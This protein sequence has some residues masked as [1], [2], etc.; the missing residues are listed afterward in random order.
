MVS[1][2]TKIRT[3]DETS[4][5][6]GNT[7]NPGEPSKQASIL[8]IITPV[9]DGTH[10]KEI[11][12]YWAS[13]VASIIKGY[14]NP[15]N[16]FKEKE[17]DERGVHNIFF[18][19]ALE[20]ELTKRFEQ[21]NRPVKS[22]DRIEIKIEDF[23]L[24]VKPDFT[25]TDSCIECKCPEKS[26]YEIPE[27]YM[28]QLECEYRATGKTTYL[29]AFQRPI[30]LLQYKPSDQRW[31]FIKQKLSEFHAKLVKKYANK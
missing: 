22:Q 28:Y 4:P 18:G 5:G 29:L 30:L 8:E 20:N 17:I 31:E 16:Y 7:N 10:K 9:N 13:E 25:T 1:R 24:V 23:I 14:V 21:K 3:T 2:K 6:G 19:V 15:T 27:R 11:G 12:K 26:I